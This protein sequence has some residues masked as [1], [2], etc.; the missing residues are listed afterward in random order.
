MAAVPSSNVNCVSNQCSGGS[1]CALGQ[2][3]VVFVNGD[4]VASVANREYFGRSM[5]EAA[6]LPLAAD[7][8][9][10]KLANGER[11]C[12]VGR[13]RDTVAKHMWEP[14][15]GFGDRVVEVVLRDDVNCVVIDF[16]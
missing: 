13:D 10:T 1:C 6:L 15:L 14:V 5:G 8:Q 7:T 4:F 9:H 2:G 3:W 12:V 16:G 11:I